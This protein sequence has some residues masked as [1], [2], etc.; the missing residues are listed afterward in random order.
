MDD[1]DELNYQYVNKDGDVMGN[2]TGKDMEGRT[3]RFNKPIHQTLATKNANAERSFNKQRKNRQIIAAGQ[4][5]HDT[6]YDSDPYW[7]RAIDIYFYVNGDGTVDLKPD[8]RYEFDF[9]SDYYDVINTLTKARDEL[10]EEG[11]KEEAKQAAKQAAA[12]EENSWLNS[13]YGLRG[14]ASMDSKKRANS[15]DHRIS[16]L[17]AELERLRQV[18]DGIDISDWGENDYDDVNNALKAHRKEMRARK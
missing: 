16:E 15:L 4:K 13:T 7:K 2:Y 5:M 14:S 1:E 11:K 18:R 12:D 9:D 17:E 6:F 10:E 3:Q 8:W